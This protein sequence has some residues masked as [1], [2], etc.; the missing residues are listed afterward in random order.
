VRPAVREQ[1][2]SLGAKF[3]ELDLETGD[4]EDSGGYAKEMDEEFY[5][6]QR[7]MMSRVLAESDVVITTAAVPGR[8]APVLIT[9][10]MVKG[11]PP[12]SVIVDLAAEQGGNCA[13]TR[14]GETVVSG[15]VQI[16]GPVNIPA[17][18]PHNA[19]TLFSKNVTSFFLALVKSNCLHARC[20]DE[21]ATS[22]LLTAEGDLVHEKVKE[23]LY[24]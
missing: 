19:S 22:S 24:G 13:L 7:E 2:E 12:G 15:G 23:A 17:T 5:R 3:I 9:E 4:A 18:L 11:M 14:A 10:D 1:V 16:L 8:K 20:G 21:I 6:K